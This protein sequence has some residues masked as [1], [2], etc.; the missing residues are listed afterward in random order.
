MTETMHS[1]ERRTNPDA[2][3]ASSSPRFA[4]VG[5]LVWTFLTFALFTAGLAMLTLAVVERSAAS[6]PAAPGQLLYD[7]ATGVSSVRR[8]AVVE[9]ERGGAP[10]ACT[11]VSTRSPAGRVVCPPDRRAIAGACDGSSPGDLLVAWGGTGWAC[12][13]NDDGKKGEVSASVLCCK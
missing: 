12:P 8:E 11:R 9:Y 6:K 10:L 3:T 7:P 13:K 4:S 2:V 5:M 1:S